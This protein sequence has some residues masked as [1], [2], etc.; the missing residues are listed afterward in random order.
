MNNLR[1]SQNPPNKVISLN[2]VTAGGE[3]WPK[4]SKDSPFLSVVGIKNINYVQC[5]LLASGYD[6]ENEV[7][8]AEACLGSWLKNEVFHDSDFR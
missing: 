8:H 1:W 4:V 7:K 3:Y 5:S 2:H 6:L